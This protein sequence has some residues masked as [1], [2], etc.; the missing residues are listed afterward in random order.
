MI[1]WLFKEDISAIKKI[2]KKLKVLDLRKYKYI[3][4]LAADK[5]TAIAKMATIKVLE[6]LAGIGANGDGLSNSGHGM[7]IQPNKNR[8]IFCLN[9]KYDAAENVFHLNLDSY[10]GLLLVTYYIIGKNQTGEDTKNIL[11]NY[12]KN[13]KARGWQFNKVW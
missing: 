4:F 13:A 3:F 7:L 6:T 8:L 1:Y 9:Q 10:L 12:F 11:E 5:Y 2:I